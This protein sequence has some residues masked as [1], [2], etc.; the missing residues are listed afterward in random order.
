VSVAPIDQYRAKLRE[1]L[2]LIDQMTAKLEASERARLEPIAVV[3]MA[4][5][6]P[7]GGVD[8]TSYWR[9][10]RQGVDA[11]R[12]IPPTRWAE[13]A[14]SAERPGA[15]YA[16]LLET[17]DEFDAPF[18][19]VS[20]READ[21]M[22]P[23]QRLLLE[24]TWEALESGGQRPDLLVGSRTGVFVGLTMLDYQRLVTE[25]RA[26]G[27]DAY[28]LIGNMSAAAAGRLSFTLGLQGPAVSVDTACSS[29]LVAVHL[30]CGSLRKRESD[31]AVAGGVNLLLS[32]VTM[33]LVAETQALAADGR[34]KS[35]DSRASGFVRSEGCGMLALKRL[36]DAERD[37]DRILAVLRGSAVNQDGR[38]TGLTTPNVLSQQALLRQALADAGLSQEDIGY[39]E[40]HGTGTSLGD[41]IEFEALRAVLGRPRADGSGCVLGAVKTNLGHLE[42]AAGVAGLIK[43]ILVHRH[44]V[45]PRNLHFRALNPRISLEG[46][47]FVIPAQEIP[48]PRGAKRRVA[49]VS[50][51]G[52]SG[53]N[54]HVIV[55]E[56][57]APVLEEEAQAR[58]IPAA[59]PILVS[60]RDEAALRG[61]AER[62]ADHLDTCADLRPL[63][64][65]FSLA[66][67]RTP[68]P[69]RL[70]L[71]VPAGAAAADIAATLRR[72]V[73]GERPSGLVTAPAGH[74]PGRVAAL[75]PGQGSQ[76]PGMGRELHETFPVFRQALD[77]VFAELDP[78]LDRPLATVMFASEG[79]EG[80]SLLHQ[81]R[82]TQPALFAVGV[83]LHRLWEHWGL[84]PDLLIGHSIGELAA[85]HVAGV[86]SLADA[87]A[88]VAA[89]G[90]LMQGMPSGGAM[91]SVEAGEAEVLPLLSGNEHRVSVAGLNGP[92]QT[93]VSGDEAAV[94][95]VVAHF[96]AL[97]RRTTRLL[98]SH[99]FHSPHM[100]GML[101]EFR[102][103]ATGLR[104]QAP[105]LALLSN[106]TGRRAG[107]DLASA[108]YWVRHARREVRFLDGMRTA[109]DEGAVTFVEYGPGGVLS[110]MAAGCLPDGA[111]AAYA[112]SLRKGVTEVESI[113]SALGALHAAGVSLDWKAVFGGLA[114]QAVELP[115]YAFQRRRHWLKPAP[116][117]AVAAGEQAGRYLLAGQRLALPDGRVLHTVE[118]GPGVQGYL[119]DHRVYGRIVLPG[120]FHLALVLAVGEAT[121]PESAIE[122]S[123]VQFVRALVFDDPSVRTTAYV[124][125]DPEGEGYRFTVATR[126]GSDWTVHAKGRVAATAAPPG[127]GP[128]LDRQRAALPAPTTPEDLFALLHTVQVDWLLR[129]RWLG[130]VSYGDRQALGQFAPPPEASWEAA[131]LPAGLLDNSFAL[132]F[133]P[134]S[135]AVGAGVTPRLPFGVER[136]IWYGHAS[137]PAWAHVAERREAEVSNDSVIGDVQ[138]WDDAGRLLATLEGLTLRRAPA[139]RFFA[140]EPLRAL[141]RMDWVARPPAESAPGAGEIAVVGDGAPA[142][143]ACAALLACGAQV[144]RF[145]ALSELRR[146]VSEGALAPATVVRAMSPV[147]AT[148]PVS[149]VH[150]TTADLLAELQGWAADE[151]LAGTRLVVLTHGAVAAAEGEEVP[152][153]AHAA[154]WGL[155]RCARN[156]HPD[157][158][159]GL[160]DV[161]DGE[162][163]P[164][165]L[166]AALLASDEPE[167]ALRRGV[168]LVPR[169]V[170]A[171]PGRFPVLG[172]MSPDGTVLITGG[173]G[174]VG[175]LV[176][177]HLVE[178]H[179][180]KHLL[181]TSRQGL[182]APGAADLAAQLA[183]LG[184]SPTVAACDVADQPALAALLATVPEQHPLTAV[185]H[186]AGLLDD[187]MLSS[188]T[189]ER[190]AAV[191]RPKADGAWN[192]H[193]LTKE[194]PLAVFVLFSGAAGL[195]G[196]AGQG[197][198]AAANTWMDALAAH[199]QALGLRATSL[200]WGPW[201]ET[202]MAA[203]LS[204]ADR[205]RLARQGLRLMSPADGLVQLDAALGRAEALLAPIDLD[206]PLLQRHADTTPVPALL[207]GLVRAPAPRVAEPAGAADA[208]RERLRG[209]SDPERQRT[210]LDLVR[211]EV[212]G[213]LGFAGAAAVPVDRPLQEVGLDSL[214][215]VELRN[216]LGALAGTRLRATVVFDHPTPRALAEVL[217]KQMAPGPDAK[218]QARPEPALD[219]SK[220][221]AAL[222]TASP[223]DLQVLKLVGPLAA[224]IGQAG[225]VPKP[226]R[227][228]LEASTMAE[229][230]SLID[231][232]LE[233]SG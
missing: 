211:G 185:F 6:F 213:V 66:T 111:V 138:M 9:T 7:G 56:A 167:A 86:F 33:A 122:L 49:G 121:W 191:L 98:V 128:G 137:R 214:M 119:A 223:E 215:A 127:T 233:S 64:L 174:G 115:T 230:F 4:C 32:A 146:A 176:A 55:E 158:W 194:Q 65:A 134:E 202:G 104:Y 193:T 161:D 35:F 92:R 125:L 28:D 218:P 54:S 207:R 232:E 102:R 117:R 226:T 210:L 74:R 99:A 41:P 26:G 45:I 96:V 188:L 78:H 79:V 61:Q 81:T 22:D 23:Q 231:E 34:C 157:R 164:S 110:A 222:R 196:N 190:V 10:L 105:R 156:E 71:T 47:P 46:T 126:A 141:Y 129:W 113:T 70:G 169:L 31:L 52:I 108:D 43:A 40:T 166:A 116:A 198:Y 131:P 12:E 189:P 13:D 85:A 118:I 95:A 94:A 106:V 139:E 168:R 160:L 186:A 148:D 73:T 83:A 82:Y 57:P 123:D 15:R 173:T 8:P 152:D 16:G 143:H 180:I 77:A 224:L 68:F 182:E 197:S 1:A 75:F 62:L 145:R 80:A 72:F 155:A 184:A 48:W 63:D 136:L 144:R 201:A 30:A 142:G 216:R 60:G 87:C 103:L 44:G 170:A 140:E 175:A 58:P 171:E 133:P 220:V 21:S 39:V 51:F 178:R 93:V 221:I 3:G 225:E 59:L 183:A 101:E 90:R 24:V 112:P 2:E 203:R 20:P 84:V 109:H 187:G 209:L 163:A 130:G 91:A 124:Q 89:R 150:A 67:T 25:R 151:R 19:G 50:S 177:R 204:P 162:A 208:L 147:D 154:L 199:R 217:L 17:V 192:L 181:L 36:S 219:M 205:S 69:S 11:V 149:A 53:T 120:A 37:R 227:V 179:G 14:V 206:L 195:L 212:A 5:R 132:L 76:R 29:S 228:A 135:V 114:A 18:F 153:L 100:D 172:P 165:L 107:E 38:S 42:S 159:L 229:L 88:L 27:F 200:A 97:G